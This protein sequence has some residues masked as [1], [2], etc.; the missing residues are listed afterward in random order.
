MRAGDRNYVKDVALC[1]PRAL[2]QQL[3]SGGKGPCFSSLRFTPE[4]F[5]RLESWEERTPLLAGVKTNTGLSK[6]LPKRP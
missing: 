6:P 5:P 4:L 1:L 3:R 2:H